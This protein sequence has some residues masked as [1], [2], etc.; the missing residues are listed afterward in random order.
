M[1]SPISGTVAETFLQRLE[2]T[3]IKYLL[4]SKNIVFYSRYM[5]DIIII[6]Y[7]THTNP[8]AILHYA[9]SVHNNLRLNPTY[10]TKGHI[11][12][13]DLLIIRKT[14]NLEI[15]IFHKPTTDTTINYLSN[16]PMEHKLAAY[17]YCIKRMLTLPLTTHW[18]HNEWK[19]ILLIA[20]KVDQYPSHRTHNQS[21][22][23]QGGKE[24]ILRSIWW[25]RF[26]TTQISHKNG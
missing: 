23:T 22:R 10:E 11:N 12:F 26:K 25:E 8:N 15:N 18:Q 17:R 14:S 6:F 24:V 20:Q 1:G 16:H 2:N 5:N 7:S 21:I 19:T 4:N 3:H 13:L 9:N